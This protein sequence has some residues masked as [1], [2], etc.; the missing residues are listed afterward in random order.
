MR[1][2]RNLTLIVFSFLLII[3][4]GLISADSCTITERASCVNPNK[5]VMGLS[6]TANAHGELAAQNNFNYVLC[7]D[8]GAGNTS[9]DGTN[10]IIGL[11][12]S[13][14]AHAETREG[15][16]YTVADVCYENLICVSASN[17]CDA[18]YNVSMNLSLSG[19][20]NAHIGGFNDYNTKICCGYQAVTPT[21]TPGNGCVEGCAPADPDCP[22]VTTPNAYWSSDGTAGI[23][24]LNVLPGATKVYMVLLNSGLLQGASISFEIYEDDATDQL[25]RT[26]IG[27][28]GINGTA[29]LEW[30]ISQADIDKAM[31]GEFGGIDGIYFKAK[32]GTSVIT[33]SGE[34]NI[35]LTSSA[36]CS[37]ITL[38]GSYDTQTACQADAN[39]CQIAKDSSNCN[40]GDCSCTWN[41][42]NGC[43]L[44]VN[45]II[46]D[47]NGDIDGDGIINLH[48][49]DADGDGVMNSPWQNVDPNG[50]IDGDGILNINDD[51]MDG[52]GILNGHDP[53]ADGD[54]VMEQSWALTILPYD[55]MDGDGILNINDSDID[56]DSILNGYDAYIGTEFISENLISL[57]T[58]NYLENTAD[59]CEDGYLEYSWKANWKW[60]SDNIL[61]LSYSGQ[62]G[63][64]QTLEDGTW[65]YDPQ[66]L[67]VS[68][69]D[70]SNPGIPCPSRVNLPFFGFYSLLISIL[71]IALIYAILILKRKSA[72]THSCKK[73]K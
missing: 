29:N 8:F 24:N 23:I 60:D 14:N 12:S 25:I 6:S 35:S 65:H 47:P 15:T 66:G 20:T 70:G 50:D 22:I 18:S 69:K 72:L 56:G 58:C 10:K 55:D 59:D 54:G 49:P 38:C 33:Q 2:K 13:T 64:I 62:E 43:M 5:I 37:G 39:T 9:C 40:T 7:C 16:A 21:C 71:S 4:I 30:Q 46:S 51:D 41:A 26:I 34:L 17:S 32:N 31:E 45:Q 52:D 68:C 11:S 3:S 63:Y 48:D 73:R 1:L 36:A 42:T 27:T 67:S 61:T 19:A 44:T 57:G 28:V 53:D